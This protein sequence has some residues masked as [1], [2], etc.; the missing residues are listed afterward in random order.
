MTVRDIHVSKI[1]DAVKQLCIEAT[2][3]L[4]D[5][6]IRALES[7]HSKEESPSGKDILVQIL[8]NARIAGDECLSLCQD[9]GMAVIFVELGQEVHLTGGDL[10]EAINHGVRQGYRDG[11]LRPSTLDP[12][13]RK[14]FEDNT[15][16]IIH[17]AIVPGENVTLHV[18]TK[19]FGGEN[20]SRVE[21]FPPSVGIEGVRQFVLDTV[22]KAGANACPPVIVGVGIGGNLEMSALIAKKSLLRPIGCR[23]ADPMIAGLE[24][25]LLEAIN[26]T[27]IGPQ[28][29]GGRITALDVHVETYPTHIGSLPVAVNLQCHSHRHKTMNI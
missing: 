4:N 12:L 11:Y 14:P 24:E 17:L 25:E 26:R 8:E 23:H 19:G 9:A 10:T 28:G 5:D 22:K 1:T 18:L 2:T 21:L 3:R 20:Q 15:P 27:G 29:L 6:M 7:S 13:T 16:A